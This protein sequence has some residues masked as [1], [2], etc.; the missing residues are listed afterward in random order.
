M[1]FNP[2]FTWQFKTEPS[3]GSGG[4]RDPDHAGPHPGRVQLDQRHDL[5]PRP[6]RRPRQ[7][8][9]ARQPRLGLC[10]HAAVLQAHRA[11]DR[12][13]A[14]TGSMAARA[15]CR[16]PT[17]TGSIRSARRS[18][19]APSAWGMPRCADYNSGDRQEGVGYFQRAIHRG[20]RHSRGAR[21]PASGEGDRT[22]GGPHRRPRRRSA[23]RRQ[24]CGGRALRGRPRPRR[25]STWCGRGAR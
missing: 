14:T 13:R 9:A 2:D 8:G 10:R 5:Q 17:S 18:S 22:A 15:T 12:H 7:L 4:R 6:A 25:A 24:A 19:P 3:E 23:V 16:S 21:V 11:A 1:L 20:W